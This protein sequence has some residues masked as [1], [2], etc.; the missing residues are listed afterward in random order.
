VWRDEALAFLIARDSHSLSDL[1][2][3]LQYEGHPPLWHLMLYLVTRFTVRPEAMQ[4]L[5]VM[6]A[7]CTVY[8][9][10]Q[11]SPLSRT[12]KILFPFGYFMLFEYGV[13]ARNYQLLLL[14]SVL[15][16]IL[17]KRQPHAFIGMGCVLGLLCFSHVLGVILA[18][19]FGAILVDDALARSRISGFRAFDRSFA[20]GALI[21]AVSAALAVELI[22]PPP[23]TGIAVSWHFVPNAAQ[24]LDVF[25]AFWNAYLPLPALQMHFWNENIVPQGI[26]SIGG[27]FCAIAG[28]WAVR[29]SRP[30]FVFLLVADLGLW[31]FFY[32][33][34]FGSWRHHGALFIA[35]LAAFWL[36]IDDPASPTPLPPHAARERRIVKN[37]FTL[38]LALHF[39]GAAIAC[40]MIWQWPFSPARD[41]AA[42]IRPQ[43]A[44]TD[45]LVARDD[46]N[47]TSIA[48]YLPGRKFF[49]QRGS[50]WGTFTISRNVFSRRNSVEWSEIFSKEYHRPVILIENVPLV[51][52]PPRAAFLGGFNNG[53]QADESYYFYRIEPPPPTP[54]TPH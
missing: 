45:L 25:R 20:I 51:N 3:N 22:I 23:D 44:P 8:L 17:R 36:M 2:Y 11:F 53:I 42:F 38:L 5:H 6:M 54:P 40:T 37:A 30:A 13:L 33:K 41:A 1:F 18:A 34:F 52:L 16:C 31:T 49:Y 19:A 35:L 28:L 29:R 47:M 50:R 15:F 10:A 27:I 32:V 4:V 46:F 7:T 9:V 43:L 26:A 12:A 39:V 48:A 14:L 21:A 24:A